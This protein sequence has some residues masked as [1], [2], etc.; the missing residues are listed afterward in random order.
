MGKNRSGAQPENG[1]QGEDAGPDAEENQ[2]AGNEYRPGSRSD[3]R[4]GFGRMMGHVD[5]DGSGGKISG[6]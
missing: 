5:E 3:G 6:V 2:G 1:E 4:L